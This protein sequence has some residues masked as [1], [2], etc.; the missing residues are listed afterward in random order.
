MRTGRRS[1]ARCSVASNGGTKL[2][3]HR[4]A[5]KPG[6]VKA[7]RERV[8]RRLG[9]VTS[10]RVEGDRWAIYFEAPANVDL[11]FLRP[12]ILPPGDV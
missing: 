1:K 10:T 2:A 7:V 3:R 4:L 5:V 6:V 9:V 8:K 11:D 12:D